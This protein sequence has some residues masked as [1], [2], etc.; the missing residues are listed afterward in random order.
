LRN[1]AFLQG[2]ERTF[3]KERKKVQGTLTQRLGLPK[4]QGHN[5]LV[6]AFLIDA[7]GTGLYLPFSLL[8][9]QK[10][11]G[12]A[13]PAI[14]VTHTAAT[15]LTLTV[16]PITGTLVDRFGGQHLVVASQLLQALGFL[17]YLIVHSIPMLLGMAFLVTAGSR[18][19][20]TAYTAL[21]AEVSDSSERD[22]WYGLVGATQWMG[23]AAGGLLAGFIVAW[24][25]DTGYRVLILANVLSFLLAAITLHWWHKTP[26]RPR[27]PRETSPHVGYRIVFVDRPF[28]AL[29][30]CNMIFVLAPFLLSTGSALYL[31]ETLK[32][33][34]VLVGELGA[35]S[36]L[37][38]FTQTL[39]IRFLSSYRRTRSLAVASLIRAVGCASYALALL[40]PH[41]L[42]I[43]YLFGTTVVNTI[44]G[45]ITTP[46]ATALAAA[47]SPAHLQGR[48]MAVYQFS[49]G[50]AAAIAPTVFTS[51]YAL[52]PTWPW[53]TI[54]VPLLVAGLVMIQIESHLPPQA[55]RV[56]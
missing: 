50:I 36:T 22:R 34:A 16:I 27:L 6:L 46:T 51:L 35:F 19:F 23:Q 24:G 39:I 55:V 14:G 53:L 42:L 48:Y 7:L 26:P 21:I 47:S 45:L 33:S 28:L 5:A 43:P 54:A 8:Y 3:T 38:I 37:L 56:Y 29:V 4:M 10:I 25:G 41:F 49:W 1:K 2:T 15:L 52:G 31:I 13:L 18:I 17:G 32:T 12:L 30:A 20:Y 9:F 11:A 40:L 44:A